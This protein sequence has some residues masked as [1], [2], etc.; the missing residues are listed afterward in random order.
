[1]QYCHT[2]TNCGRLIDI[3]SDSPLLCYLKPKYVTYYLLMIT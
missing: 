1:M 2:N 3:T